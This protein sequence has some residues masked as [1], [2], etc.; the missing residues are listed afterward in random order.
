[1]FVVCVIV[2]SLWV[3]DQAGLLTLPVV[4]ESAQAATGGQGVLDPAVVARPLTSPEVRLVQRKLK[5]LGFDPGAIDG[6]PGRQIGVEGG[7]QAGDGLEDQPRHR[8]Q[9]AGVR[10]IR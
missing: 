7:R 4:A 6:V 2:M 10:G 5:S 3:A 9:P 1:M 8:R